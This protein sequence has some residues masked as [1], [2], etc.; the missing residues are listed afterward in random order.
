MKIELQTLISKIKDI[1]YL[2]SVGK[3][4]KAK[5]LTQELRKELEK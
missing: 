2:I 1:E 3:Y 4:R 5:E